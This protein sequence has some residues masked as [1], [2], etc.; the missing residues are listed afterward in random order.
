MWRSFI[1]E[2]FALAT[3]DLLLKPWWMLAQ[4]IYVSSL[5]YE[6]NEVVSSLYVYW[7]F[8]MYLLVEA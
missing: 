7:M 5:N 2:L 1:F 6:T 3:I 4:I 8:E